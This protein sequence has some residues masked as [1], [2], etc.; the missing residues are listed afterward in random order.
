MKITN[1]LKS[2]IN[3]QLDAK[4]AEA[5]KANSE[6]FTKAKEA[7][8]P[9]LVTELEQ[10]YHTCESVRITFEHKFYGGFDAKSIIKSNL[11]YFPCMD[12]ATKEY[13]EENSRISDAYTKDYEMLTIAISYEKE[14]KGIMDAFERCGLAF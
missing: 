6:R 5:K 11:E 14:L 13:R 10:A 9:R 1:E 7:V 12:E 3:R 2:K 4:Y 8:M